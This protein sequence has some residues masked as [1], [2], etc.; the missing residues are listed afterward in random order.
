[1]PV[2]AV[3]GAIGE[4]AEKAYSMGVSSIFSINR[5]AVAF[6]EARCHSAE[7]L[8]ATIESLMRFSKIYDN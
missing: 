4:G 6:E 2:I 1:M 5:A 7:N 8:A 3:V